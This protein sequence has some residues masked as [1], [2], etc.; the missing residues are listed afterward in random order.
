MESGIS[1][2]E[3]QGHQDGEMYTSILNTHSLPEWQQETVFE[4]Q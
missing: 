3:E 1:S 4:R 2:L